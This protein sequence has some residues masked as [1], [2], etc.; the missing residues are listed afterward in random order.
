MGI[1]QD[2]FFSGRFEVVQTDRVT[3]KK[4]TVSGL[5]TIEGRWNAESMK[6][7]IE[8]SNRDPNLQFQIEPVRTGER[9]FRAAAFGG[10]EV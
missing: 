7:R 6:K 2:H 5:K 10:P 9:R 3:G 4:Q 1:S 8:A